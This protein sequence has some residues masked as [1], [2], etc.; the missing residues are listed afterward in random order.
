MTDAEKI[1]KILYCMHFDMDMADYE[2][3]RKEDLK[4]IWYELELIADFFTCRSEDS[5]LLQI[6][7]NLAMQAED[8]W[9]DTISTMEIE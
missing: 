2:E 4:R 6:I 1:A 9:K 3:T 7:Y 5:V 8:L